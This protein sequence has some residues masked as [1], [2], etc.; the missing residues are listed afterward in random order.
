[1]DE[2]QRKIIVEELQGLLRTMA[3][4][5]PTSPAEGA[6]NERVR[7]VASKILS[8]VENDTERMRREQSNQ[9]SRGGVF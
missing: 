8:M 2:E 5:V 9:S 3:R 6:G 4:D 1:M 7:Q